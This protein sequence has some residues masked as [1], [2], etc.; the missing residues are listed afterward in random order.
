M[1]RPNHKDHREFFALVETCLSNK[2]D[3]AAVLIASDWLEEN[4]FRDLAMNFLDLADLVSEVNDG[5]VEHYVNNR[6]RIITR[7][8]DI[9]NY[10]D[11][12][13]P[14]ISTVDRMRSNIILSYRAADS[15]PAVH[16]QSKPS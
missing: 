13:E 4:D 3:V 2:L 7:W 5:E 12:F 15:P 14:Y 11:Y 8:Y 10:L 16:D 1:Y 6:V 9:L